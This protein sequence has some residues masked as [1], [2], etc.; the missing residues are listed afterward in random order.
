MADPTYQTG[1]YHR[2][3]GNALVVASGAYILMESG[4]SFYLGT[5]QVTQAQMTNAVYAQN[6]VVTFGSATTALTNSNI[7]YSQKF[8]RISFA[9]NAVQ[10]SMWLTSSPVV[11]QELVIIADPGSVASGSCVISMSGCALEYLGYSYSVMHLINS[12]NSAPV[13][14]LACVADGTW[15]VIHHETVSVTFG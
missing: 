5:L 12:T 13:V 2:Q 4:S 8:V 6:N 3:G 15:S 14:H 1:V 9:S 7:Y 10:W 11:G